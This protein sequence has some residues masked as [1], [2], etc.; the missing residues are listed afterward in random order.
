V[1]VVLDVAALVGQEV[2]ESSLLDEVVLGVD[3][4]V[5]DLLLGGDEP[6]HLGLLGVVSPL[7][8]ELLALVASVHVVELS[9]LRANHEGEVTQLRD[10]EVEGK[11]VFVMEDHSSE[12][13]VVR[14]RAHARKGCDGTNV[15]EEEDETTAGARK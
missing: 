5:L 12:P 9:E 14:P 7:G 3:A 11:D 4:N 1:E 8:N 6:F 10:T 13:L 15:E 2:D